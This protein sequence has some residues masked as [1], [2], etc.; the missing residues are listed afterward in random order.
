MS[1]KVTVLPAGREFLVEPGQTVLDAALAAGIVLPYSCRNGTCST[2]QGRVVSGEY[3][4]GQAPARILDAADLAQGHTLLCQARPNSDLLIEAREVRMADDIVVRKMPVRVLSLDPLA[5]DVM[6]ISLQLPSAEAFRFQPGQYLEF[7]LKDG[8]R[9]SYSMACGQL[10]D[11]RLRLH[12]RHM[13]GGLFTSRV[14]GVGAEPLKPRDI[15]RIE[16]PLGS[17]FLDPDDSRPI[18]F[19][20]SGTGFAPI[21]AMVE[22]MLA[23]GDTR[24]ATLYWGGRRPADLYRQDLALGWQDRLPGFRYVPVLSE[25]APDDGWEGRTGW[26]HLAV[27]ADLPDLSGHQVYACGNPAMVEAAR[28]DFIEQCGLAPE[29]F[30]ADAF[31]SAADLARVDA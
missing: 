26:V 1:F 22:G 18:V 30:H 24:P 14:F 17:F 21:Q 4:A 28:R 31:T 9:R 25:A 19:L 7:I 5:P 11:H 29:A 10:E 8:S 23:R 20:A 3:D 27:M 2:C 12:V 15:L 13:P 16:G 6:E